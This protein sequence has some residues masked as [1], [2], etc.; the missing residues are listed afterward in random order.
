MIVFA[1][2]AVALLGVSH[3]IMGLVWFRKP[4]AAALKEGGVGKFQGIDSR[5]VAFWF[6]IFG[7]ALLA[8]GHVAILAAGRGDLVTLRTIGCYLLVL[9]VIGVLALPKSGFWG[10][11]VLAPILIGAGYGWFA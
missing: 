9:S 1:A 11:L 2:W 8:L 7:P 6:T 3:T 10:A 5:R 4:I